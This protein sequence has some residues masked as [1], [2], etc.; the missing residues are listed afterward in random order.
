[1]WNKK[2]NSGKRIFLS[3]VP[4]E[5]N[6]LRNRE[7]L[8]MTT[9][10]DSST[11]WEFEDDFITLINRIREDKEFAQECYAALCNMRW[12]SGENLEKVYSCSWRYAGGLIASLR[13]K[14]EDYLHWYCSGIGGD[15]VPEGEVTS[16]VREAFNTLG[17][18]EYPWDNH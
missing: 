11:A 13:G 3:E 9:S 5:S 10:V 2:E 8:K 7:G 12:R 1:M 4:N 6:N 15:S 17:W 18:F 14:G 16:R